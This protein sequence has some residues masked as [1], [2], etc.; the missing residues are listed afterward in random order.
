MEEG[1]SGVN[2]WIGFTDLFV[3][4]MLF[5]L[6]GLT[7][8]LQQYGRSPQEVQ[9]LAEDLRIA[10][11]ALH[12]PGRSP[13]EVRFSKELTQTMNEATAITKS[14][15]EDLEKRLPGDVPSPLYAETEIIIPSA[16]LFRSFGFDDFLDEESKKKLLAAIGEALRESLGGAGERRQFLRI[17]VEGHTDSDPIKAEAVT[18]EIPTNWE[19][20]ARRATGVLRFFE[21][22]G[23]TAKEYKI[24]AMGLADTVPAAGNDT[25]KGKAE[26]RRIVIRVEPDIRAIQTYLKRLRETSR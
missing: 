12:Q 21:Q 2:I 8:I 19:L 18:R 16:A 6:M 11:E 17:V 1:R 13:E 22:L 4:L 24:V 5:T 25:D 7:V 9:V 3:G 10:Q 15:R 14:I 26:N 20:S 23:V